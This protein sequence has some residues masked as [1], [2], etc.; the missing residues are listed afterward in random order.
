M[1]RREATARPL[2]S[3]SFVEEVEALLRP[4][5]LPRK[6]GPKPKAKRKAERD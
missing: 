4:T 2:G 6:R 5:L 3:R 1:R